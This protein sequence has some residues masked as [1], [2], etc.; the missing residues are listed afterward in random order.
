MRKGPGKE[1]G[2]GQ[3]PEV[4]HAKEL[5]HS[6][7][8][9]LRY[10][11]ATQCIAPF[12]S[13]GAETLRRGGSCSEVILPETGTGPGFHPSSLRPETPLSSMYVHRYEH[14]HVRNF[15]KKAT[16]PGRRAQPEAVQANFI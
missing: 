5:G 10:N 9:V 1:G 13:R 12:Y 15:F 2:Q 7:G 3:A 8:R 4:D 6:P 14:T 16:A 11:S